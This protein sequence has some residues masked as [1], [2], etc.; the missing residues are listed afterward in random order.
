MDRLRPIGDPHISNRWMALLSV[1]WRSFSAPLAHRLLLSSGIFHFYRPSGVRSRRG[2]SVDIVIQ[3]HMMQ[4]KQ[5]QQLSFEDF[6]A[7]AT[8]HKLTNHGRTAAVKF[9][10]KD[11][12]FV[13]A[14][15]E[16]GLRQAHKSQVNNALYWHSESPLRDM[17]K[18][19]LPTPEAL[20]DY[21]DLITKFPIAASLV[22]FYV[23]RDYLGTLNARYCFPNE[24]EQRTLAHVMDAFG[25]LV[26]RTERI[27]LLE[28]AD[29]IAERYDVTEPRTRVAVEALRS[30]AGLSKYVSH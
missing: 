23:E 1:L 17:P 2:G 26:E 15:G 12:G 13:D 8:I 16:R 29:R 24:E 7:C 4:P 11:L 28:F 30:S 19:A 20:A 10:E 3:E 21:P 14:I 22:G 27:S 9:G 25:Y 5:P 6:R 18:P